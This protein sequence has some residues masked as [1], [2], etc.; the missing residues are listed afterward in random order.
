MDD[1]TDA[2]AEHRPTQ[3]G[4]GERAALVGMAVIVSLF[5]NIV[6][7]MVLEPLAG[8]HP[9]RAVAIGLSMAIFF[10]IAYGA[11]S[12]R[13]FLTTAGMCLVAASALEWW[14]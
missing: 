11:R 14:D 3:P 8:R 2:P 9:A 12:I 7:R 4:G 5:V 10:E 1:G 6:L 13:S